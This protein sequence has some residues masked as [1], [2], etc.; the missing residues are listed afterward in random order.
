MK[1]RIKTILIAVILTTLC[2]FNSNAQ[3]EKCGC[4]SAP[5][6]QMTAWGK[7]NIILRE[8]DVFKLLIGKVTAGGKAL[9]GV[10]VEVFHNPEG[11]LM[12]WKERE[13]MKSKQKKIAACVTNLN[14]RF[15]FPKL[16]PG[17]YEVRFSKAVGWDSTSIYIIVD[18]TS[19]HSKN[20]KLIVRMQISQ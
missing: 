8:P 19:S 17:K 1:M 7:Q 3:T 2:I 18:P 14:G 12:D 10:L 4:Q 6:D 9:P 16:D 15:C 13:A 11:L 20:K 5:A